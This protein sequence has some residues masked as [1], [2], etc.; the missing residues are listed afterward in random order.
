MVGDEVI[1]SLEHVSKSF[2]KPDGGT[3]LVL[4][5][6]NLDIHDG[7]IVVLLGR[8]GCGKSTQLRIIAGL[9]A[10]TSGTVRYHGAEL[11][12]ANPGAAM[13]FQNFALM[14]WLTVQ[15]N[16][17]LGLAARGVAPAERHQRAQS[18]INMIGLGGFESAYPK[19]LSG[20]M[21]QRVGFARALVLRP[22]LLLMDEPF[23]ALDVLTAENL[24]NELHTR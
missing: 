23:S 12:G 16:V 17:E 19:E 21:R 3:L 4:D 15:S 22:D 11:T 6:I 13:V 18:A 10:V 5:D 2:A 20:G 9:I 7:E 8:S 1:I 24:R 14:P